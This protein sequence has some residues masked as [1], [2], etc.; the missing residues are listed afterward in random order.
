[1]RN[2][3]G[4]G[5]LFPIRAHSHDRSLDCGT[6]HLAANGPTFLRRLSRPA[7]RGANGRQV[8]DQIV[9]LRD[10]SFAQS[11]RHGSHVGAALWPDRDRLPVTLGPQVKMGREPGAR[12]I[13]HD[14][15]TAGAAGNISRS[16][17]G[18]LGPGAGQRATFGDDVAADF[19]PVAVARAAQSLLNYLAGGINCIGRLAANPFC[20]AIRH[21]DGAR[22]RPVPRQPQEGAC[23][24]RFRMSLRRNEQKSR[25]QHCCFEA[26]SRGF[27]SK[28][29]HDFRFPIPLPWSQ[30]CR[31]PNRVWLRADA[32]VALIRM[33]FIAVFTSFLTG[34]IANRPRKL[35]F[36]WNRAA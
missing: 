31:G 19:K 20:G 17:A 10:L 8:A 2:C 14:L 23:R 15:R 18:R 6:L 4:N 27:Q 21:G 22:T 35:N 9:G 1:M 30:V 24:T 13:H 28:E 36:R 11:D 26:A 12:H 7:L 5:G 16:T 34:F 32:L 33:I 3:S 25:R 29:G